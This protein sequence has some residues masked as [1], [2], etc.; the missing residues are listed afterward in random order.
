LIANISCSQ[1]KEERNSSYPKPKHLNIVFVIVDDLDFDEVNFYDN[2]QFPCNTYDQLHGRSN[3]AHYDNRK[4]KMPTLDK[5]A[6]EAAVFNRFYTPS[7][8]CTPS[9]FTT[10][11]GRYAHQ[12]VYN[13]DTAHQYSKIEF[14][15]YIS[16]SEDNIAKR[17]N[18]LGYQT[19]YFGK[20]HNGQNNQNIYLPGNEEPGVRQG[21][22]KEK[23]NYSK[24]VNYL[25]DSIGFDVADRLMSENQQMHNVDWIDEGV[26]QF[27][28]SNYAEPFFMYISL[29]IP[30][31]PYRKLKDINTRYTSAGALVKNPEVPNNIETAKDENGGNNDYAAM[32]TWLDGS[33]ANLMDKLEE[34]NLQENT[35]IVFTS[36]HQS[37]GKMTVYESARVPTFFWYPSQIE[38]QT[39]NELGTF[40]DFAP[41]FASFG[42]GTSTT[43]DRGL[44]LTPLLTKGE[45][46]ERTHLFLECSR[47]RGVVTEDYKYIERPF[48]TNDTRFRYE[49]SE[50]FPHYEERYQLYNLLDD[51]SEQENLI[52]RGEYRIIQ[53]SLSKL[54]HNF[55]LE[56]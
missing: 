37:R 55:Y 16:P 18:A 23:Q 13:T 15:T 7:P 3:N 1:K 24:F 22:E 48:D 34:Y 44:D 33:M 14:R 41:T 47:F 29:P 50:Q 12:Y 46:P 9:R 30:H 20:Y 4:F 53:D 36:D 45:S 19:G 25:Q 26:R 40:L 5:L 17:M 11:T 51:F 10:L 28:D 2:E 35:L 27:V 43:S 42:G 39:R 52:D 38:A 31:G 32:A 6:S 56:P 49:N 21:Y 8:V 54:L